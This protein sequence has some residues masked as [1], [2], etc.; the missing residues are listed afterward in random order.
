MPF[1]ALTEKAF[2]RLVNEQYE[3]LQRGIAVQRRLER[4]VLEERGLE[5]IAAT[6]SSAVG[7]TVAILDG[8]G[9]PLAARGFRREL[10]EEAAAAIRSEA[11]RPRRRRPPLRPRPP[12]GRRA[13]A[14]PPGR[15]ARRRTAAG[16][17]GRSSAT[18]A[19]SA[20][21]SG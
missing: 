13:G 11:A 17:G 16:L 21:S 14:R 6:I 20:T 7:G 15:L 18:P 9:E 12:L 3:V 4:L 2:A 19:A 10:S 5:E 8:R 1:I